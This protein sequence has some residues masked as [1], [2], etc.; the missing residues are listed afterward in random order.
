MGAV[1]S[2]TAAAVQ[3]TTA[4]PV[5]ATTVLVSGFDC[6]SC[7]NGNG[8]F[9]AIVYNGT[10]PVCTAVAADAASM[11]GV[12]IP[13]SFGHPAYNCTFFADSACQSFIYE[14]DATAGSSSVRPAIGSRLG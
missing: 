8:A 13:A 2:T 6:S 4:S 5:Q 12:R 11:Y 14:I 7:S 1:Q 3:T 10:E 9:E